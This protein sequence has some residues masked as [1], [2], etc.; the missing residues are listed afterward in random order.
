MP[1]RRL[2][3]SCASVGRERYV[4]EEDKDPGSR[5]HLSGVFGWLN[6]A[7]L[8]PSYTILYPKGGYLPVLG[9]VAPQI[10]HCSSGVWGLGFRAPGLIAVR[11]GPVK[12]QNC[13]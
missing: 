3:T 5:N 9:T 10:K 1:K 4:E 2:Y 8:H 11:L 13:G 6:L 12:A 7:R